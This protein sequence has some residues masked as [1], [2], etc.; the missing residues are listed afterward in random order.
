[1]HDMNEQ[2]IENYSILLYKPTI[3]LNIEFQYKNPNFKKPKFKKP[4]KLIK[5]SLHKLDNI[6]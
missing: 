3:D 6:I 2:M 5:L 4:N 1:M